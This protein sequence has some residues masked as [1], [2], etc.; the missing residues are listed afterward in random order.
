MWQVH[1]LQ[2]SDIAL[3]KPFP[4]SPWPGAN[5]NDPSQTRLTLPQSIYLIVYCATHLPIQRRPVCIVNSS[6]ETAWTA[7]APPLPTLLA[8]EKSFD[9]LFAKGREKWA[10]YFPISTCQD[11]LYPQSV[12]QSISQSKHSWVVRRRESIVCVWME[13]TCAIV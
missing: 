2:H 1:I 13:G 6:Y 8:E 7:H 3:D 12:G 5:K 10:S 11:E 9:L 4:P